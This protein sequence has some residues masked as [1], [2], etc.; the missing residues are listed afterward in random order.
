MV[1]S[2][3]GTVGVPARTWNCSPDVQNAEDWGISGL[4]R[5][6][7]AGW[8]LGATQGPEAAHS[9]DLG[10]HGVIRGWI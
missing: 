9:E 10:H 6:R 1:T 3:H 8:G 7:S 5:S 4:R 2:L